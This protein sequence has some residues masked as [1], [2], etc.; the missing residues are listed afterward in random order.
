MSHSTPEANSE[1]AVMHNRRSFLAALGASA[2]V[3]ATSTA[4]LLNDGASTASKDDPAEVGPGSRNQT[5][6]HFTRVVLLG[7]AGGPGLF[8]DQVSCGVST[9]VVYGE[10]VYI[11]DLGAGALAN[12]N[13]SGVGGSTGRQDSVGTLLDNVRGVFFTH[14]HSDHMVD[15]PTLYATAP[16]N[17]I[18]RSGDPIR[19]FGPGPRT[20]L[21][22]LF[23]P[24]RP[25][26][27]PVNPTQPA[28]G[29]SDMTSSLRLAFATDFND[30]IRDANLA[31]PSTRFTITDIDLTGVWEVDAPGIPPRLDKPL[32]VWVDGDVT[33]TATLVDHRPTA[34]A[35]AYR[36]DTPDG[37]V[38]ISG[39]TTVSA[40]LIDLARGADC[41]VHE[42][43]DPAFVDEVTS[44]L[45]PDIALSAR[46]HLLGSHT[47]IEQ[48]GR[49]V[50]QPAGVKQ[51]VLS[52]FVPASGPA[53]RWDDAATGFDGAVVVGHDLLQ[54]GVGERTR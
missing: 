53:A 6:D 22:R 16:A 8:E 33:V 26:V 48:V 19:V 7:T 21:P 42:V 29:I 37:S 20:E 5:V 18:K 49:D 13:R 44:N 39:D 4:L 2:A 31:D 32:S 50:A 43:V 14:M 27:P 1:P 25:E 35:F 15:W 9:A 36:F 46:E 28:G 40:N 34:P 17:S 3:G 41:L 47:T 52:H 24:S 23:P 30:R 54:V 51:L 11:V 12:L 45:P 10:R 38:V